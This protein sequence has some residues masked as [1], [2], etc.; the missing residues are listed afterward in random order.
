MSGMQALRFQGWGGSMRDLAARAT[1]TR[2]PAAFVDRPPMFKLQAQ[3]ALPTAYPRSFYLTPMLLPL[4]REMP[5][6]KVGVDVTCTALQVVTV[7]GWCCAVC[8]AS[9]ALT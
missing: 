8:A 1:A 6:G 2:P 7:G 3:A 4:L 9:A 5:A